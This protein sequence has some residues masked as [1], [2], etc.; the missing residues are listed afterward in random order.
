M[1][2]DDGDDDDN[3]DDDGMS[4]TSY[5]VE[6]VRGTIIFKKSMR[7]ASMLASDDPSRVKRD[8]HSQS[9][10]QRTTLT[11]LLYL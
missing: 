10:I 11:K 3:D 9:F 6:M 8:F 5:F 7:D 1:S 4:E 2:Y